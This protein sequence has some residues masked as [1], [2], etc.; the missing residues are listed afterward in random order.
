MQRY[1]EDFEGLKEESHNE[2]QK[3]KAS[4]DTLTHDNDTL[5][6]QFSNAQD[7]LSEKDTALLQLTKEVNEY[8]ERAYAE[9]DSI[10]QGNDDLHWGLSGMKTSSSLDVGGAEEKKMSE[11]DILK[12]RNTELENEVEDLIAHLV[13]AKVQLA[14]TMDELNNLQYERM[15]E[16]RRS[17]TNR[18]L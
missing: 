3:L 7:L 14:N 5:R 4:V 10:D 16:L 18:Q 12:Q 15:K 9:E 6:L 11:M 2:I 13:K 17:R 8:R 1:K